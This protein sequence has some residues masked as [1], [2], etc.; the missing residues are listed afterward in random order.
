MPGKLA[1]DADEIL[2]RTLCTFARKRKAIASA[3]EYQSIDFVPSD[4]WRIWNLEASLHHHGI[5]S[6]G[7]GSI[8]LTLPRWKDDF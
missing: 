3:H 2:V 8:K 4:E 6:E 1:D 5:C 7:V